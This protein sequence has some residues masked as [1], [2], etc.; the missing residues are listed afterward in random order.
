MITIKQ[1]Y[2]SFESVKALE[3]INITVKKGT[4]YGIIGENGA[5]KT[6]LIKTLV[7]IYE[8]DAGEITVEGEPVYDNNKVKSKIGYVADQNQYFTTYRI[9]DLIQFYKATYPSFSEDF[10]HQA[11]EKMG[12][13]IKKKVYQ[14]SKGMQMRLAL[15][16]NL[17]IQPEILVL[18]EPTSG[19]DAIVKKEVLDLIIQEVEQ[20][21]MTVFISSH[22]LNEL[23]RICDEISIIHKGHVTYQSSVDDLKQKVKKVQVI[24]EESIP[25]NLNEWEEVIDVNRIGSVHYI[26]TK[27]YSAKF[28]EKIQKCGVKLLETI[29]LTLEE[30]FVYTNKE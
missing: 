23:E 15:L 20:R 19:L 16:L 14:L 13:D 22:H 2:K 30:I 11:N 1:V 29:P 28:E 7:G 17:S 6:T 12:L 18:D 9:S 27:N 4:I 8:Q 3:N 5:G 26:I 21:Q 10:F 25:D 24:F